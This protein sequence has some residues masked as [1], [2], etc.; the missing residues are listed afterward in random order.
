MHVWFLQ[1][2]EAAGGAG[3]AESGGLLSLNL[4]AGCYRSQSYEPHAASFWE[5]LLLSSPLLFHL[6]QISVSG[7][8]PGQPLKEERLGLQAPA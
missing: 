3:G 5:P 1:P 7:D 8:R 4:R 2:Q 6:T